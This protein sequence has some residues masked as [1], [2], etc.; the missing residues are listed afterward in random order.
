MYKAYSAI[1]IRISIKS[2]KNAP[3]KTSFT[4]YVQFL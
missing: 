1:Y 2:R 3:N 4:K